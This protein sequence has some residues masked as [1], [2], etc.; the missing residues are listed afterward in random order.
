MSIAT[1]PGPFVAELR[2]LIKIPDNCVS[3]DIRIRLNQAVEL[4]CVCHAEMKPG[5]TFE[6]RYRLEEIT[7]AG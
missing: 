5:A 6:K 7:A 2:K 4:T 3:I 1:A